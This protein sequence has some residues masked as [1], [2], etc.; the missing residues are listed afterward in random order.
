LRTHASLQKMARIRKKLQRKMLANP[1][2]RTLNL[3]ALLSKGLREKDPDLWHYVLDAKRGCFPSVH[4]ILYVQS[5][6]YLFLRK[7]EGNYRDAIASLLD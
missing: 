6:V 4:D 7:L 3:D 1:I 2:V 5:L